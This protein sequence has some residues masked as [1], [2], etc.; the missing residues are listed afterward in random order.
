MGFN[1]GF[2]GLKYQKIVG[3]QNIR[4]SICNIHL[5]EF[6]NIE[7]DQM[8]ILSSLVKQQYSCYNLN[9]TLNYI[10]YAFQRYRYPH[11]RPWRHSR[12]RGIALYSFIT[13]VLDCGWCLVPRPGRLTPGRKAG[14]ASGPFWTGVGGKEN[15][16]PLPQLEPRTVHWPCVFNPLNA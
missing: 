1:S 4:C 2:K 6:F 10:L 9:F 12:F 14:W 5:L 16:L 3:V 13:F 7:W 15:L 8:A 11:D